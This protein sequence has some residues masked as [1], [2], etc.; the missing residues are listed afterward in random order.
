MSRVKV[1]VNLRAKNQVTLPGSVVST[2]DLQP[3]DRLIVEFDDEHPDQ[4]QLRAFRRSY[5]GVLAGLF[6]TPEEAETYVRE[7]RTSWDQ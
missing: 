7:E 3:G 4:V 1:A 2:L 5:E 6:G